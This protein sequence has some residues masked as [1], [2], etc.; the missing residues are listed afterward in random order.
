M[1]LS[2]HRRRARPCPR[3]RDRTSL[4]IRSYRGQKLPRIMPPQSEASEDP[5]G[6]SVYGI[7]VTSTS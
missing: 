6:P 4:C 7:I 2:V 5:W 1:A 3:A